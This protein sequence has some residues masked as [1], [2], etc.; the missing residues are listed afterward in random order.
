MSKEKKAARSLSKRLKRKLF[1]RF[2][3]VFLAMDLV[4][5]LLC[6]GG[7]FVWAENR[8]SEAAQLVEEGGLPREGDWAA[9][10]GCSVTRLDRPPEGEPL[11]FFQSDAVTARGLRRHFP[12]QRAYRL[13][14]TA[15]SG[16]SYGITLDYSGPATVLARCGLILLACQLVTLLVTRIKNNAT[17]ERAFQPLTELAQA[18]S[19][20][21]T[22]PAGALDDLA[23]RLAGINATRLDTRLPEEGMLQELRPLVRAINAMLERI[24]GAYAAQLRFVSDASHEL[25][26]PIAVIQ[27]Y[28]RLL[29]RWGKDDPTARQEAIDAISAETASMQAL[30]ERLL[31]LA[32]GDNDTIALKCCLFD[33]GEMAGDVLRE[34]AMVD[35]GA[36]A[37]RGDWTEGVTLYGDPE[38]L[39]EA[40]RVLVD[41]A[42]KYSPAGEPV[43]VA[44]R[45][46]KGEGAIS[47][48]DRG[49]GIDGEA[50]PHVFDRFYRADSSRSRGTGGTG[51]GLAIARWIT[52]RHGGRLEAASVPQLGTRFTMTLPAAPGQTGKEKA[53]PA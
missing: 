50:L 26:T 43:T 41:N 49:V 29:D 18:A 10:S 16:E 53:P 2:F 22:P 46:T 52:D 13:E 30:V 1:W 3:S 32:R 38:L 25:R 4:L 7:L 19:H 51:L 44:I 8:L 31:F 12:A 48:T 42:V 23:G 21:G 47:V 6:A 15:Q 36:H 27:G 17:V 14:F 37:L 34:T 5:C 9:L 24:D 20:L 39:K 45:E 33:A 35:G 28:A 40:L 11:R